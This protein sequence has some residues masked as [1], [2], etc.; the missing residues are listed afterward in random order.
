MSATSPQPLDELTRLAAAGSYGAHPNK[1]FSDIMK[2]HGGDNKLPKAHL[3]KLPLKGHA[4]DVLQAM[5][6]PHELFFMIYNHYPDTWSRSILPDNDMGNVENF[7]N[8]VDGHPSLTHPR[9]GGLQKNTHPFGPAR[10][11][12][13]IDRARQS[14]AAGFHKLQFL[15]FAWPGQHRRAFILYMG[16]I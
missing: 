3:F 9:Q 7:W 10:G 15:Q 11:R 12:G 6:L 1:C 5:I 13:A 8:A 14:L 16:V 4:D 2:K